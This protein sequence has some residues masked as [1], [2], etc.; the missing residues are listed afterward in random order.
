MMEVKLGWWN[1]LSCDWQ[2]QMKMLIM[3]IPIISSYHFGN[4][5]DTEQGKELI[6]YTKHCNNSF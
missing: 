4:N 1:V 3:I 2:D 6:N 5:G